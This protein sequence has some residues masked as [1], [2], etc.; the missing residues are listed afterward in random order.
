MTC[1][2]FFARQIEDIPGVLYDY[3]NDWEETV[4]GKRAGTP[5]VPTVS[6]R[7]STEERAAREDATPGT[8]TTV[9][10]SQRPGVEDSQRPGVEDSRR[11]GVEDSQRP[12]VETGPV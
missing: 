9:E 5:R 4:K 10:D 7:V 3:D 2:V 8:T 1:S 6:K 12:G 11:P